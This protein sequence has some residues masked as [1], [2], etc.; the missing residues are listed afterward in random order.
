MELHLV[1]RRDGRYKMLMCL[2]KK[3]D[4]LRLIRCVKLFFIPC[5]LIIHKSFFYFIHKKVFLLNLK[6]KL[7]RDNKII[8]FY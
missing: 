8:L 2:P 3:E 7:K 1:G 6:K 4:A 5:E